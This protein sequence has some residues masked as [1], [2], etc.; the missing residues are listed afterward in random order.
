MDSQKP[1]E[2]LLSKSRGITREQRVVFFVN[3]LKEC[4][5]NNVQICKPQT[6]HLAL[7]LAKK[8]E[9]KEVQWRSRYSWLDRRRNMSSSI[10][11]KAS[12]FALVK[13]SG[14]EKDNTTKLNKVSSSKVTMIKKKTSFNDERVVFFSDEK[15]AP[16]QRS[17]QLCLLDTRSVKEI[18]EMKCK[19]DPIVL[20]QGAKPQIS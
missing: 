18:E 10:D 11:S 5:R 12:D 20:L 4:I 14:N 9:Q 19:S 17:K 15:Y 3:G 8:Y 6:L 7:L 1:F 16:R 13:W 2:V